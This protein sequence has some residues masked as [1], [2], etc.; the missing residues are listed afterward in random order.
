[1]ATCGISAEFRLTPALWRNIGEISADSVWSS[2]VTTAGHTYTQ[3]PGQNGRGGAELWDWAT[4]RVASQG[5][6]PHPCCAA[7]TFANVVSN[8]LEFLCN[9][10]YLLQMPV[11]SA[12]NGLNTL[13]RPP[14]ILHRPA[15]IKLE[16]H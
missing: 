2:D 5:L 12:Y 8:L 7:L 11:S 1:M 16:S 15:G 6:S 4:G 9:V 13:P 14:A 10:I 3:S